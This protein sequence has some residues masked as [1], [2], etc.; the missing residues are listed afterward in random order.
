MLSDNNTCPRHV[1]SF[2]PKCGNPDFLY[3]ENGSF[4]CESCSF[5]LFINAASAVAV[6]IFNNKGE[7]LLTKRAVE[8]CKG[9]LDLPGGFVDIKETA[10]EAIVREIKEE[11]NIDVLESEYLM[12]SPNEYVFGGLSVFTLDLAFKCKVASYTEIK[13]QDDVDGFEF[14]NIENIPFERIGAISIKQIIYNYLKNAKK[15]NK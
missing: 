11:L 10:E 4:L 8:P 6:L 14:H 3:N 2:C 9:M 5:N 12:S 13:V 1:I 7:L 15:K